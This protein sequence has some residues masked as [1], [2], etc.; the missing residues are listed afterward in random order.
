MNET[1]LTDTQLAARY[2][3]HRTTLWRWAKKDPAF[4]KPV[5]LSPGCTR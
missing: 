4:P 5:S 2:G 3:I 1:Y